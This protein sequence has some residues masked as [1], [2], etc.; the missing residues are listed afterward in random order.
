[1]AIGKEVASDCQ[2]EPSKGSWCLPAAQIS[3]GAGK[4]QGRFAQDD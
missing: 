3:D 4:N 2:P 1:M